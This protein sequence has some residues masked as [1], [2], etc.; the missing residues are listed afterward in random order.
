VAAKA[1]AAQTGHPK[2]KNE[3]MT[4]KIPSESRNHAFTPIPAN[5]WVWS[6]E[7]FHQVAFPFKISNAFSTCLNR[8]PLPPESD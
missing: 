4:V 2:A 5:L 3:K 8:T 1:Q 6:Q 7:F